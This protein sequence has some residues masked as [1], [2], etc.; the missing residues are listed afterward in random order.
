MGRVKTH[1]SPINFTPRQYETAIIE[2][3]IQRF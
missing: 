3:T 1:T 2:E